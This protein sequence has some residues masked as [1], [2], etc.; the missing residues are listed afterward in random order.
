MHDPDE[1]FVTGDPRPDA[2]A[3]ALR[4]RYRIGVR[5]LETIAPDRLDVVASEREGG[6]RRYDRPLTLELWYPAR[7]SSDRGGTVYRAMLPRQPGSRSAAAAFT[8]AGRARRDAE[9]DRTAAPY[10]LVVLS[11]GHTGSRFS[12]TYLAENL[13]SKGFVV[14]AIDHTDSIT[15]LEA[16]FAST[17]LNRPLDQLFVLDEMERRSRAT[18]GFASGLI[19]VSRSAI[20]GYSMGGYGALNVAGAGFEAN[21][22]EHSTVPEGALAERQAGRVQGD[23]RVKAVVAIAPWGGPEALAAIG[24]PG[25]ACWDDAGLAELKVP[26]LFIAGS[27]DDIS[28][29][30]QG[31]R[32]LFERAVASERHLLLY[33]NARHNIG[34]NPPPAEAW[35]DLDTY[36]RFAEPAWSIARLNNLNQHFVTAFLGLH[37]EG[38]STRGY[39][40]GPVRGDW[41]GFG[42]RTEVGI[43]LHRGE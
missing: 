19:E 40:D 32:W 5:S 25:L 6:A 1:S 13:A 38:E 36:M 15:G 10:P 31:V 11:H 27:D 39:L 37:L 20:I 29:Y 8:F 23:P 14:A 12:M 9:A 3:L 17:L 34:A 18:A 30:E 26:T 4:G 33:R 7:R 42:P 2:P 28:G 41:T 16:N 24:V 21:F 35:R 43:E 22:V